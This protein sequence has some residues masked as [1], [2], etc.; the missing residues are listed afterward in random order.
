MGT[1]DPDYQIL[2]V[3]YFPNASL[4]S[5]SK[6]AL[7]LHNQLIPY[8]HVHQVPTMLDQLTALWLE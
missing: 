1:R 8:F 5:I 7:A 4:Q 2:I 6:T 3:K